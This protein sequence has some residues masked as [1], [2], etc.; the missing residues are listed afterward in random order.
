MPLEPDTSPQPLKSDLGFV[1]SPSELEEMSQQLQG[2]A[3]CLEFIRSLETT[4]NLCKDLGGAEQPAPLD[5]A[6]HQ[7][8]LRAY[9]AVRSAARGAHNGA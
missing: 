7:Q 4:V 9:T 6:V 8:L 2:C 3:P 5:P 1:L